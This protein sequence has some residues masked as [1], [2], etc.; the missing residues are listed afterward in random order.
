VSGSG[1]TV[2]APVA[3]LV[4]PSATEPGA[5]V[6]W[7]VITAT[8]RSR[9]RSVHRNPQASP[10][11]H[12]VIIRNRQTDSIRSDS[13]RAGTP[14]AGLQ[15]TPSAPSERCGHPAVAGW[16]VTDQLPTLRKSIEEFDFDHACGL[17]RDLIAHLGTLDFVADGVR[18]QPRGSAPPQMSNDAAGFAA[19]YGPLSCSDHRGLQRCGP[20]WPVSKPDRQPATALPATTGPDDHLCA[21]LV[22]DPC[23]E[24]SGGGGQAV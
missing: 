2:R 21:T 20:T 14:Q 11:R 3:V 8:P 10:R 16:V 6:R 15:S 5:S 1:A 23:Y 18:C 9:S 17:K 19:R 4:G 24:A 22:A 12:P 13:T 7:L